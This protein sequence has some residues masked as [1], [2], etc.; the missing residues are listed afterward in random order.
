MGVGWICHGSLL[1]ISDVDNLVNGDRKSICFAIGCYPAHFPTVLCIGEAFIKNPNGGS[2]AFIGNTCIGWGGNTSDPDHYTVLQDRLFYRNLFD[3]GFERLGENFSDLKNDAFSP[4]DPYNLNKY[5]FTQLHLLS[6]PALLV[7]TAD[8]QSLTVTHNNT[9]NVGEYSTFPVQV[10]CGGAP[11]AY[12]TVCLWKDGDVYEVEQTD[13]SGTATF[14]FTPAS[15]G[16]MLVTVTC[17]NYLPYEGQAVVQ[18]N[19]PAIPTV[20]EWGM[21]VLTL[22]LLCT[23]CIILIRSRMLVPN[24]ARQ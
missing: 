20:T 3:D 24:R 13:A 11:V 1:V 10:E 6:D 23:G 16:T 19:A 12:A 4:I 14:G 18:T 9:V 2:V 17:Q 5:C 15:T 21:V 7:W 22:V 8:P